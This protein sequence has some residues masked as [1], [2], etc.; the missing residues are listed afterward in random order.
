[1]FS[2][3]LFNQYIIKA[4]VKEELVQEELRVKCVV[5]DLSKINYVKECSDMI[6]AIN[7]YQ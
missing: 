4:R 1:M 3:A 6:D 7:K 5:N 2:E